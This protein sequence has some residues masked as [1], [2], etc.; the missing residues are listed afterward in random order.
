MKHVIVCLAALASTTPALAANRFDAA[1]DVTPPSPGPAPERDRWGWAVPDYARLQSGG[2][3]GLVNVAGGY[4]ALRDVLNFQ[5]EYGFVPPLEKESSV[6][7][8]AGLLLIR[9][10]RLAL[11]PRERFWL[12]PLYA[13]G[14]AMVASAAG[15]FIRQPSVYPKGY[16]PPNGFHFVALFG[17][18]LALR[19]DAG[20][21]I[22]R[23]ALTVE[24]ITIDQ[25]LDAINQ[26]RSMSPFSAFSTAL[27]YKLGF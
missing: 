12:Y 10:L 21:F 11:G 23:H 20:Q 6:H 9:P 2:F 25:Y 7:F 13:G 5:L 17:A 18:E 1:L 24:V 8:G 14:G 27:G 19:P 26:N 22:T 3:L 15:L 4:S 16:Y